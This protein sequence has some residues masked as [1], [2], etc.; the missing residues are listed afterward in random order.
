MNT[1]VVVTWDGLTNIARQ[2][3]SEDDRLTEAKLVASGLTVVGDQ[4]TQDGR[5]EAGP[6]CNR[7][8]GLFNF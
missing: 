6:G 4:T 8:R 1:A 7:R 2:R 5:K 3:R